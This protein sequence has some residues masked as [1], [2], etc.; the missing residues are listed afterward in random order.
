MVTWQVFWLKGT[1]EWAPPVPKAAGDS[2]TLALQESATV[3]GI[4][5]LFT[6]SLEDDTF[7]FTVASNNWVRTTA[8]ARTGTYSWTNT[9]IADSQQSDVVINVPTGSTELHLWYIVSSEANWD[10]FRVLVDGVQVFQD[11]GTSVTTWREQVFDVTGKS[12]VTLRYFKDSSQSVGDDAVYVDDIAFYGPIAIGPPP[13]PKAGTDNLTLSLGEV[14]TVVPVNHQQLF[15]DAI[16]TQ[17]NLTGAVTAIDEDPDAPDANWLTGAGAV[18]LRVSFPT[19]TQNLQPT[20]SQEF[21]VRVRP[22]T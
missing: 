7:D 1:G 14:A 12:Q 15:P 5:A 13:E 4:G 18:T 22:G 3:A 19:P 8:K 2:V 17:T 20:F 21:R 9:D 16:L 11:S 6:E 10:F